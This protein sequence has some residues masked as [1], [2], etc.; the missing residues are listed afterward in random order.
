M[1]GHVFSAIQSPEAAPL[2]DS[3][4]LSCT[5][6]DPQTQGMFEVFLAYFVPM[7]GV[8]S[9]GCTTRV[10]KADQGQ[11]GVQCRKPGTKKVG[12]MPLES[13]FERFHHRIPTHFIQGDLEVCS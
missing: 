12:G 4:R 3:Q 8:L 1:F 7:N 5:P 9:S 2:C 11:V 10:G 13:R 6:V